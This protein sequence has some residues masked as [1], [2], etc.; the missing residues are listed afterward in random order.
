MQIEK[1]KMLIKQAFIKIKTA[2][3]KDFRK[4]L[5]LEI[6]KKFFLLILAIYLKINIRIL[7]L[8]INSFLSY[9][10][11]IFLVAYSLYGVKGSDCNNTHVV[12]IFITSYFVITSVKLYVLCKVPVTRKFLDDLLTKEYII[13]Y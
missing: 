9:L 5:S 10:V 3:V 6:L 7:H 2:T 4:T 12:S 1:L 11:Y 13:K 8:F